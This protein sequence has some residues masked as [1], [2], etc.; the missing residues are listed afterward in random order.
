MTKYIII[1]SDTKSISSPL[2]L[3]KTLK[4]IRKYSEMGICAYIVSL[5][6]INLHKKRS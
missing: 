6:N 2:S 3:E 5:N 4:S 1:R